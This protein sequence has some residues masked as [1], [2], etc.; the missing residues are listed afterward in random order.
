MNTKKTRLAAVLLLTLSPLAQAAAPAQEPWSWMVAPYGWFAGVSTDV[1]VPAPP[2]GGNANDLEFND[3]VDLLDG[4]FQVH[5]EGQGDQ[6]GAFADFTYLG[7]ADEKEFDRFDS[8]SDLDTRLFELAA[9]WS[10]GEERFKGLDV[11][12]GLR[13]I[14]LDVTVRLDPVNPT[15]QTTSLDG[16]KSYSDFMLG[17]RYTFDVSERFGVTLRGDGSGGETEGSWNASVMGNYKMKHGAFLFGY[18][19]FSV[20]LG[21]DTTDIEIMLQGPVLGYAWKF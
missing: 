3:V 7:L 10:P 6:F 5:A 13:Y 14:D 12:A 8:Q 2:P 11:F 20:E 21:N 4:A 19:Y 18:R 1:A 16:G 15:F 17:A 9:V